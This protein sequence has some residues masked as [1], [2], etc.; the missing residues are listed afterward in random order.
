MY[1]PSAA[2]SLLAMAVAQSSPA[3]TLAAKRF[4]NRSVRIGPTIAVTTIRTIMAFSAASS[5]SRSPSTLIASKP[6]SAA[7]NVAATWGTDS[8]QMVSPSYLE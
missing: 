5:M 6:T 3:S 2:G 1:P 8:D 7:A 4:P